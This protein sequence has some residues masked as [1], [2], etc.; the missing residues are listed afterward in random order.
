[1][2]TGGTISS[3]G[4]D[5]LDTIDYVTGGQGE[6]Q[7]YTVDELLEQ[8]PEAVSV[9]DVTAVPFRTVPSTEIGPPV[10]LELLELLHR[11]DAEQGERLDGIVITHGTASLEETVSPILTCGGLPAS[12]GTGGQAY[13]LSLTLKL[14]VPVVLV[15]S[16]RPV[17]GLSSDAGMN[18]VCALRVAG[19]PDSRGLGVLVRQPSPPQAATLT[20]PW[21]LTQQLGPGG[22]E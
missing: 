19:A 3:V 12:Q 22:F 15:G 4:K 20:W 6:Q 8:V 17:S 13:F 11:V 9:A 10:W 1:M 16:Q 5:S 18:L 14:T 21:P 2:G 7:I